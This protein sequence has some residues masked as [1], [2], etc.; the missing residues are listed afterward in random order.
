MVQNDFRGVPE[1]AE[2]QAHQGLLAM[3]ILRPA[4]GKNQFF[5]WLNLL[6]RATETVYRSIL[7]MH[8]EAVFAADLHI[9]QCDYGAVIGGGMKPLGKFLG[10]NP[11]AKDP[12]TRR[13]ECAP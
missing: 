13:G 8:F 7:V 5:G 11:G 4:P 9:E 6:I 1:V 12:L 10:I 2:L 3:E